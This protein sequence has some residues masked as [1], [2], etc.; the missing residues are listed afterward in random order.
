M[1]RL[2]IWLLALLR[3]EVPFLLDK[4]SDIFRTPVE[5]NSRQEAKDMEP[6]RPGIQ[7]RGPAASSSQDEKFPG[8]RT[9]G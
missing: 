4:M 5:V 2:L 8:C 6:L 9:Q 7:L 1:R 3:L